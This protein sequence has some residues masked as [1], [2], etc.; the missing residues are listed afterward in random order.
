LSALHE[1]SPKDDIELF[2]LRQ[3]NGVSRRLRANSNW[4]FAHAMKRLDQ[5]TEISNAAFTHFTSPPYP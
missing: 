4:E 2:F 5:T 1:R 3:E